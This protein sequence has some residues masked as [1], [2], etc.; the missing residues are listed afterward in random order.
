MSTIRVYISVHTLLFDILRD[1]FDRIERSS[2]QEIIDF[3]NDDVM[4]AMI[5][6]TD[7]NFL[8]Q[9]LKTKLLMQ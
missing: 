1:T 7:K 6:A 4:I 5:S 9:I 2:K 3:I 8:Q